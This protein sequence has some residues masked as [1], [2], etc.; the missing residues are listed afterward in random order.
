MKLT[1]SLLFSLFHHVE[2]GKVEEPIGATT[3][4]L[5]TNKQI[6]MKIAGFNLGLP[7]TKALIP[8]LTSTRP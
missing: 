3:E 7:T 4:H 6:E 2:K 1:P 5:A 8:H